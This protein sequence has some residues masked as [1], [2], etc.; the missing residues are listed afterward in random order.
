MILVGSLRCIIPQVAKL[1][2]KSEILAEFHI[3]VWKGKIP[4][5]SATAFSSLS[6]RGRPRA[7]GAEQAPVERSACKGNFH[8]KI[9]A[10]QKKETEVSM[11]LSNFVLLK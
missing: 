3:K 8:W 9:P 11:R 1:R 5:R 7:E 4:I 6:L 10:T 2:I